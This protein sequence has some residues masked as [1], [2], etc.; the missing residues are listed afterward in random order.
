MKT[1]S[2]GVAGLMASLLFASHVAAESSKEAPI[3]VM[4]LGTY[5]MANPGQDIANMQ[6][7]DVLTPK[8]QKEIAAVSKALATFNPTVVAVE[9]Q[10]PAPS[11]IDEGYASFTDETLRTTRNERAQ[12]GYRVA[13]LAG[14]DTVYGVDEQPSDGEPDYFPMGKLSAHAKETGQADKLGALFGYAQSMVERFG[15]MQETASVAD[16]LIEANTGELSSAEFYYGLFEYDRGEDQPGAELQAYWFMRNAKIFSKLLQVAEPGD[17]V[18]MV[19]GAGH[20]HWLEHLAEETPGVTMVD[21][22]PYLEKAR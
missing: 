19:Y 22:A 17:R 6:A 10:S 8:R 21:P 13:R 14:L 12:I 2:A 18:L 3:Q 1:K 5:H 16:L 7:D 15:K 11:Y 4:V 9:R 20:K